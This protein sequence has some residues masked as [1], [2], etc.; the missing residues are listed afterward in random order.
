[1]E[2]PLL[3]IRGERKDF[4]G[5]YLKDNEVTIVDFWVK[6]RIKNLIPLTDTQKRR[7]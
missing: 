2:C 1:L 7:R 5:K 6:G 4:L 3:P